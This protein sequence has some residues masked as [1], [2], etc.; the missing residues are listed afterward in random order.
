M[1]CRTRD[2]KLRDSKWTSWSVL[3]F[4]LI[5]TLCLTFMKVKEYER[6]EYKILKGYTM[7]RLIFL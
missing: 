3:G 2:L 7:Y 1:G 5:K 6:C 4:L